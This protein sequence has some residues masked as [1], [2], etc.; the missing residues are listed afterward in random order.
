MYAHIMVTVNG[1]NAYAGMDWQALLH[2]F[3]FFFCFFFIVNGKSCSCIVKIF[4]YY[5]HSYL[6]IVSCLVANLWEQKQKPNRKASIMVE[7]ELTEEISYWLFK[8]YVRLRENK[9][10]S[11]FTYKKRYTH[12]V[13]LTFSANFGPLSV[14]K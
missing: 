8:N 7:Q 3:D 6:W 9:K 11:P 2:Y 4:N 13:F 12:W 1:A 5:F 10:P 14:L